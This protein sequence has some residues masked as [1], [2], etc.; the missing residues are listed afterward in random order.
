MMS[1]CQQ[2]RDVMPDA[3]MFEPLGSTW[4]YFTPAIGDPILQAESCF[5]EA[6]TFAG[7]QEK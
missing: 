5:M 4:W 3:C 1:I 2:V 6:Q 7:F